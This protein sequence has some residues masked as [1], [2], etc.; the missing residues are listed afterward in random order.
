MK[1]IFTLALAF[2]TSVTLFSQ[3]T[4]PDASKPY[5]ILDST[6]TL[7]SIN[8]ASNTSVD[9]Y[10]DNT[11]GNTVKGI[12]F[13]FNY[14]NNVFDEPTVTYNNTSGPVGYMSTDIDT[15]NG[16]VKVVWVYDGSS[17]TFDIITG[18]MFSVE[19]PFLNTYANGTVNG[20]DFT[21]DLTAYYSTA[22]GTDAL[23][24]TSDYGGEFVEPVFDYVATILNNSTNPAENTFV[25]PCVSSNLFSI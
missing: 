5:V 22:T 15:A 17:T 21:T 4:A 9:I 2:M 8:S 14:D 13:S 24:G 20:I 3:T 1:R 16:I 19:L 12:Q 7:E 25:C 18:N 6:Y 23:L 10:Y 11:S